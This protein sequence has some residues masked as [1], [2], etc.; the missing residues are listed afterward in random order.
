MQ[1]QEGLPPTLFR[2][3][4][5]TLANRAFP[6]MV[7]DYIGALN[8]YL[9]WVA[10]GLFGVSVES[11]RGMTVL[12][13]MITL[14]MAFGAARCLAGWRVGGLTALL[15]A[16]HPA[17]VFWTRQGVYVTSYALTLAL[18]ALWLL[19]RWWRGGRSWNL[20]LA[21]F[22]MGVGVWGKLLFVW[23]IGGVLGAWVILNV[24]H[25]YRWLRGR[26]ALREGAKSPFMSFAGAALCALLGLSPLIAYNLRSGGTLENIF[27][28]FDE[29]YY[30]VDNS[31]VGANFRER[32]RQAPLVFGGGH[33]RELGGQF[34]NPLARAWLIGS[35][36]ACLLAGGL[37]REKRGVY[38]FMP[39]LVMLMVA[40]SS[41]TSTALWFTHFALILPF[42][43]MLGA[44]GVLA[45]GDVLARARGAHYITPLLVMLFFTFDL[46]NLYRY[47]DVLRQT[48]GINTHSAAIYALVEELD[49]LPPHSPVAALDWGIAPSV[50]MLTKGRITPNEVFGY[51]WQPDAGFAA[52]LAPFFA[53]EESLYVLHVEGETVFPRR[54]AFFQ[55]AAAQGR[56]LALDHTIQDQSGNP[57]FEIWRADP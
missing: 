20:L 1:L 23:F 47:H 22:L 14:G 46:L 10:F 4:G 43:V 54:E 32:L 26:E 48:G 38:W 21:A 56:E 31:A 45:L 41:F 25:L 57:Y 3:T 29:S 30:G 16:V 53:L 5:F 51:T 9:A 18:A 12:T 39:L 37:R 50:E 36:A 19:V 49:R 24:P 2:N 42:M 40:Q 8:V 11:L 6:L 7:Q 27:I 52:R 33:L 15:L 35:G 28:N 55:A 44:V 13:G 34:S 17:F